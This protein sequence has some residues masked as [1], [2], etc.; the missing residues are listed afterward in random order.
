MRNRILLIVFLVFWG[1]LGWAAKM[2]SGLH[3]GK[4][5]DGA[6]IV[7]S[8]QRIEPGAIAF[9][10]RPTDI[11]RHPSGAFYAVLGQNRV[12]LGDKNGIWEDSSAKLNDGAGFHGLCWTPDGTRLFAS[13][14]NGDLQ[15]FTRNGKTLVNA[16]KLPILLA[17]AK[18]NGRP[19]GMCITKDGKTLFVVL[20]D[21]NSVAQVDLTANAFVREY[22]TQML[23]FTVKLSG[24]EKTLIVTNWGGRSPE[25]E[26]E[27][28]ESAEA[29]IVVDPRG[30]PASGTVSLIDRATE[31][32]THLAIGLHPT[33][34]A[35]DESSNV[36]YIANAASD[37]ISV[38]DL[39]GRK[40]RETKPLRWG[41][42]NLF[43]SMPCALALHGGTLYIAN[44][45]D[46]AL[47]EWD[48]KTG[49]VRG[50][51]PA[52]Y[53][54]VGIALGGDGKTA[55]VVNAKGNGSVRRT[56]KGEIGNAHDFQGT[57]SVLDLTT[58]LKTATAEVAEDA[59]WNRSRTALTP[60]IAVYNG[61]IQHVLYII[62]E[63]RTYDE[64]FGD[65][66]QG[67]GNEKLCGLGREITP[68]HHA[69]AE[70]FT[71]FDNGYVSGTNSADGHAWSNQALANDYLEHFYTGYRTYP[72]DGDCA[73]SIPTSGNLWDAAAKKR[74]Q[75]GFMV[76]LPTTD[77]PS[78]IRR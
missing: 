9:D 73:M 22:K 75:F 7:S 56:S 41:K 18:G 49:T 72:D 31:L 62:K 74:E 50:Y 71:L 5:G 57:V 29:F 24:D 13:I 17:D 44:G 67:N 37:S 48:T 40:V 77:W 16:G 26:D 54:P 19:G 28:A 30:A 32:A 51:R 45:G 66:P 21:R 53:Y 2:I 27:T 58:D 20:M 39:T 10:G 36:A 70:Q 1:G 78:S 47:C 52:G 33:D 63:N 34:I 25:K 61:A 60:K 68:N 11:A 35:V 65:L 76:S 43:G 46:N 14:S 42:M 55:F 12:F 15:A 64:V 59:G 38:V 6:F 23:P 4:Q 69:L 3:L 8:V